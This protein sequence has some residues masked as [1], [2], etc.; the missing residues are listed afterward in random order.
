MLLW[1]ELILL[2]LLV[3]LVFGT[4][5]SVL[6]RTRDQNSRGWFWTGFFGWPL[7]IIV[8]LLLPKVSRNTCCPRCGHNLT[9]SVALNVADTAPTSENLVEKILAPFK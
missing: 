8:L 1:I 6:A 5:A 2:F 3:S 7:A 4:A 9:V